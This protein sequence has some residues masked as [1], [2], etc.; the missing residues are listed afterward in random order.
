MRESGN[1]IIQNLGEPLR[2][3]DIMNRCVAVTGSCGFLGRY[4]TERLLDRGDWVYAV[5]ALTYA[6]DPDL[7]LLWQEV[8]PGGRFKFVCR[9]INELGA[10]PE[11]DAVINLAA[12]TH[13]CNS[14][15]SSGR[16]MAT[17][18]LGVHHLLEMT[19]A[20]AHNGMPT[21]VQISTDEVYGDIHTGETDEDAP[22]NPSSPYA[23]SK[24][25]G[26]AL[27]LAWGRTFGVPYRIIRPSNCYGAHQYPE[28]LIPKAVRRLVLGQPIPIHGDGSAE[29]SWLWVEDCADAILTVLDKGTDGEVYNVPGNTILSVAEVARQIIAAFGGGQMQT[30]FERPGLDRRYCVTGHKLGPLGW[31]PKGYFPRDLPG[32]VKREQETMRW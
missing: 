26:D 15:E 20:R 27:V 12:E 3:G 30:G 2:G 8:Y 1:A 5:D 10:W 22:F 24:A 32:I 11:V 31:Q 29:R 9:D 13:V 16:F 14:I 18:I 21:F 23:A 17:N 28:K 25:S 19:R 6:A 4:V 7:P